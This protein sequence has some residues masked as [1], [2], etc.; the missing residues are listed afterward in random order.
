MRKSNK[1]L[2]VVK[3]G[4]AKARRLR[5][6]RKLRFAPPAKSR[7]RRAVAPGVRG[8][9]PSVRNVALSDT[10][11]GLCAKCQWNSRPATRLVTWEYWCRGEWRQ[12]RRARCDKH[13][14]S[15]KNRVEK[16]RPQGSS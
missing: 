3:K 13:A 14:R 9:G 8:K 4:P 2:K 7:V 10:D 1:P 6:R 16:A 15:L 11:G 12:A 5:R